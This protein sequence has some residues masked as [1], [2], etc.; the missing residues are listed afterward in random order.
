MT[1]AQ[2]RPSFPKPIN[3]IFFI[4]M[5]IPLDR[6]YHYIE[7]IAKEIRGDDVLIYR[8]YPHG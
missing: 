2:S 7:N 5:S 8:F 1:S 3:P 4:F 6:L